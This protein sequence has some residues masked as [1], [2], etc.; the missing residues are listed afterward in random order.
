MEDREKKIIQIEFGH[1][2][3]IISIKVFRTW[4]GKIN[5]VS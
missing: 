2:M 1:E 3:E 4:T 5:Y